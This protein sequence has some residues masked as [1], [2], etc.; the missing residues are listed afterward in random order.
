[1][2]REIALQSDR[3]WVP[4]YPKGIPEH[5]DYPAEPVSWLLEEA[6]RVVPSRIACRFFRQQFTYEQLLDR[7]RR[8][9]A[10]LQARGLK[11]GDR[12]G[13][14]LPNCP[15]YLIAAFGAWMGGFVTVPLNPLMVSEEIAA[16]IKSTG[17]RA[18]V[19]LD[20]LLP[21]L[22]SDDS[23]KPDVVFA[24]TLRDRLPWWDRFLYSLVRVRRL[25]FDSHSHIRKRGVNEVNF[26]EAIA[27]ASAA[28]ELP[29][30]DPNSPANILP[31][32]GTT[33]RPKAVVLTHRNLLA[34]AWQLF[35]WTGQRR[36]EDVILA[37][38][39]FFHSYGLTVCGLSG[40]AMGATLILHHRFQAETILKLIERTRPTLVPA[41]PAMLAAFNKVLIKR[42]YDIS[43]VKAV[44]SG[45]APLNP[46]VAAEFAHRGK[47]VVVQ[48]YGLSEASP[49]THV[50]PLDGTARPG[51]IGIPLPD[52]DALVVDADMGMEVLP[53]GQ[54]GELII[55]APQVMQGYWNDP[56][57]TALALR[58]GWL[59][60]GDLATRD[61]DGFFK[62]VDRKKD[63]IITSGVNVYPTDVEHVLKQ[64]EDVEDIAVLGVPD[65]VRG[66]LVKA[67]VVPKAGVKFRRKAFEEYARQH[68]E[69]HK[70]PRIIAVV[71]G[72]LPRN[73]L[74]KVLR[75]I[76]RDQKTTSIEEGDNQAHH[77]EIDAKISSDNFSPGPTR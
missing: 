60:T 51:T 2:P 73:P 47:A 25:G 13:I 74:G 75:R 44:I 1:M 19:C 15:E 49:V 7:C 58:D 61:A 70:R 33:G 6:A 35:Y 28:T 38:L 39:P 76:L 14:L 32:G 62:I 20:L 21:L 42:N 12:V 8:M 18:V 26:D 22:C 27:N 16:L 43:S 23:A 59:Y 11:P 72:P 54:V 56:E 67:F 48:G 34:N 37:C 71:P 65:L 77:G 45:G 66:E 31:T 50:G 17:C 30:I 57:A 63:L 24:T 53:P 68:L 52:T 10:A 3:V 4:H 29:H 9:A 5:L 64:F 69:V 46:D 40:I 36:G 41:V 55:R